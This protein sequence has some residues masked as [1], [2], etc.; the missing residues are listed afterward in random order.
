MNR[1]SLNET[2]ICLLELHNCPIEKRTSYHISAMEVLDD[3]IYQWYQS[4]NIEQTYIDWRES[5][6]EMIVK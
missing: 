2:A 4:F 3:M 1:L 6:F 5:F